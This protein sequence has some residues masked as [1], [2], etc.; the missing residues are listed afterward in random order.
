[1]R[2]KL[3]RSI[4][5]IFDKLKHEC[6]LSLLA[7]A[8]SRGIGNAMNADGSIEFCIVAITEVRLMRKSR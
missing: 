7:I 5:R 3:A 1:M 4:I 6:S 8:F 2:E